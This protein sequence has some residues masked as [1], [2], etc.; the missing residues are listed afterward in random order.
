MGG[1]GVEKKKIKFTIGTGRRRRAGLKFFY[2]RDW[3]WEEKKK[4]I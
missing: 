2:N 1:A 4:V 3:E